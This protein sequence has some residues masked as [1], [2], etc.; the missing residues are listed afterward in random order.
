M[1]SVSV[2][3]H[4]LI[5]LTGPMMGMVLGYMYLWVWL[6]G[7]LITVPLLCAPIFLKKKIAYLLSF[8][9]FIIWLFCGYNLS[10]F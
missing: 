2:V 8:F 4:P 5:I 6:I 10:Y 3:H 9:G 7:G 1:Q